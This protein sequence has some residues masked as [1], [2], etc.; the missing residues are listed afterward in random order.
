M[1]CC[2][3]LNDVLPPPVPA[4]VLGSS[5]EKYLKFEDA[6]GKITT[7][8]KDCPSLNTK[9]TTENE[10]P[11]F[12]YIASRVVATKNCSLSSKTRCTFS[13]NRKLSVKDERILEDILFSCGMVISS[14]N[15]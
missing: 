8:E 4:P 7:T 11:G 3:K 15:L 1:S 9:D 12:K 14:N 2:T 5:N 13:H 10:T 6:Y